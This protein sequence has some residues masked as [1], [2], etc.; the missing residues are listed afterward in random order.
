VAKE[1]LLAI[2]RGVSMDDVL[3]EDD[4]DDEGSQ[5]DPPDEQ[6]VVR[7]TKIPTIRICIMQDK[8]T[9][10]DGSKR[11]KTEG[12]SARE[13]FE[14]RRAVELNTVS[15][16]MYLFMRGAGT[17]WDKETRTQTWISEAPETWGG[18]CY[19]SELG[20]FPA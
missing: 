10:W 17:L 12:L 15:V 16:P 7:L 9:F 4:E 1:L 19:S 14:L 5:D 8:E 2:A 6:P 3:M 13:M 11:Q 20:A 18:L